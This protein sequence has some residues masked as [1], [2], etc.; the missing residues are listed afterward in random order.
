MLCYP[1]LIR[2]LCGEAGVDLSEFEEDIPMNNPIRLPQPLDQPLQFQENINIGIV[3]CAPPRRPTKKQ[4]VGTEAPSTSAPV[5]QV[6]AGIEREAEQVDAGQPT[7]KNEEM[8]HAPEIQE[9]NPQET[10]VEPESASFQDTQPR[11]QVLT[12]INN[13]IKTLI[14]NQQEWARKLHDLVAQQ[15]ELM[16]RYLEDKEKD[17]QE[18]QEIERSRQEERNQIN[19]LIALVTTTAGREAVQ[20]ARTIPEDTQP[21]PG[22]SANQGD[23]N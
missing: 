7:N 6:E 16:K 13:G 9:E 15:Q 3:H 14:A 5:E 19:Q 4:R 1:N 18:R 11:E 8:P 20:Q 12:E 10:H 2:R 22:T 21:Q 17:R 23:Q